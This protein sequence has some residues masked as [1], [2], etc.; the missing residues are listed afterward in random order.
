M[1]RLPVGPPDGSLG[2]FLLDSGIGTSVVSPSLRNRLQ[3]RDGGESFTGQRM[4]GQTV[5]APLVPLAAAWVRIA[6]THRPDA[7]GCEGVL[8]TCNLSRSTACKSPRAAVQA[9]RLQVL[10]TPS[11]VDLGQSVGDD[12]FDGI[13]G[14]DA[15]GDW[16]VTIGPFAGTVSLHDGDVIAPGTIPVPVRV[17]RQARPVRLFTDVELPGGSVAHVEIDSGSGCLILDSRFMD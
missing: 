9:T 17:E 8:K 6:R 13:I 4:S 3:L 1:I 15:L 12:G 16:A 5:T 10:H 7:Y 2:R 14:L 11:V